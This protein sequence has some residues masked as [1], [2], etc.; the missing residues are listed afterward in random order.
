[1]ARKHPKYTYAVKG[2]RYWRFRH[3]LIGDVPLPGSPDSAEFHIKYGQLLQQIGRP[4]VEVNQRSFAWLTKQYAKSVEFKRLSDP[5]QT[6][7]QATLDLI[8]RDLGD[9]EFRITTRAMIKAVRDKYAAAT[10]RKAHK[11]KQ[12]VSRLYGW[13]G[14]NS[15]VPDDFNPARGIK[16]LKPKGGAREITVWS[17]YEIDLFCSKCPPH[18]LTPVLLA[19]YTG[20]RREDIVRMTWQQ[21]QGGVV[22][23]RQSKTHALLDIGCHSALRRHLEVLRSK[24]KG[25]VICTSIEGRAYTANSLSQALRRAV[26]MIEGMPAD[27][28]MHGLR[29]AAGSRMEEAGCTIAEIEAVLGHRTHAMAM[30]YASQRL[31]AKAAVEK[32]EARDAS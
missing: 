22:R 32:T 24:A 20:Q 2:G 10:P 21:F 1:V 11:I 14:E 25:V 12:M 19:L 13:A 31:R 26:T 27:R 3:R 28:S 4:V 17:D 6:D 23:V 8:D 9:Q 16:E 30:K 18:V 15:Y 7:Y 5:T 29:Y